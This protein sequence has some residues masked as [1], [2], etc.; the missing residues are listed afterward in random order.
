MAVEERYA[1][2]VEEILSHRQDNGGDCWTTPDHR[3]LKGSPFNMLECMTY[4]MELGMEPADPVLQVCFDLLFSTWKKDGR[5]KL[6]PKGGIFPCQT[7]FAARVLCT[8]GYA[9]DARVQATLRHL[10]DTR[11][12]DGGWRCNKFYFGRGPETEHANPHPTLMALDAFRLA[13]L[14]DKETS[15]D[16]A[17][18]FLLGHWETKAPLGPCHY[19]IGSRFMQVEY[20]FRDYNLFFYVYVLSFYAKARGDERFKQALAALRAKTVDGQIVVERVSPK[21]AKLAFCKKGEPSALATKRYD[22]ILS[23]L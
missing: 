17:V 6:Y 12:T 15:L 9:T 18:E 13:G 22:E 19:G 11:Y 8:G 4:L 20:P 21:M 1:A 16:T 3:L 7:A 5:F 14:A 10:L 2:D 23:N